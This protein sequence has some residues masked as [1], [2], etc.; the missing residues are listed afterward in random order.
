MEVKYSF[1]R[2]QRKVTRDHF[3]KILL[4]VVIGLSA[5]DQKSWIWQP[6]K[7]EA[8]TRDFPDRLIV[9]DANQAW[10]T[11]DERAQNAVNNVTVKLSDSEFRQTLCDSLRTRSGF[12]LMFCLHCGKEIPDQSTFCMVC[13]KPISLGAK[14]VRSQIWL[15]LLLGALLLGA[16]VAALK[17]IVDRRTPTLPADATQAQPQPVAG[18]SEVK[19]TDH[20]SAVPPKQPPPHKL[21]PGEIAAT[22]SIQTQ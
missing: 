5:A 13:G 17:Y 14:R 21:T 6:T 19:T 20:P 18:S 8:F 10:L 1:R 16:L 11:L 9:Q 4:P 15:V 22:Y 12:G 2:G 3:V 7:A